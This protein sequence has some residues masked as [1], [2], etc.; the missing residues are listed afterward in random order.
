M[1]LEITQVM[2]GD[3][4][5]WRHDTSNSA[6]RFTVM[7]ISLEGQAQLRPIKKSHLQV[8]VC[9]VVGCY[10]HLSSAWHGVVNCMVADFLWK[11]ERRMEVYVD[12]S[13]RQKTKLTL[14][15]LSHHC[16]TQ[17]G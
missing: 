1:M 17:T 2:V 4:V 6:V 15:E 14:H 7:N 13:D 11:K 5:G 16:P 3:T 12:L 10:M 9:A 8:S